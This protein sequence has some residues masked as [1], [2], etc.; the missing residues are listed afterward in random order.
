LNKSKK[1]EKLTKEKD[2]N[3]KSDSVREAVMKKGA[4]QR[5][6]EGAQ[7][8]KFGKQ[9]VAK[10]LVKRKRKSSEQQKAVS[11]ICKEGFW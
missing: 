3:A 8:K 2:K 1:G 5:K 4:H 6:S 11:N 10:E 7:E 9:E